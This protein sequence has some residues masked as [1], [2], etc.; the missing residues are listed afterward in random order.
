MTDGEMSKLEQL[1][2]QW[3]SGDYESV[4]AGCA[5]VDGDGFWFGAVCLFE[6]PYHHAVGQDS[7]ILQACRHRHRSACAAERCIPK[8]KKREGIR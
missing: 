7:Q 2:E 8:L 5:I 3:L 4:V 6:S 1:R